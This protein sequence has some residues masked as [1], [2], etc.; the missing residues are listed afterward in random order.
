MNSDNLSRRDTYIAEHRAYVS[1]L[2]RRMIRQYGLPDFM[3]EDLKAAGFLGL[4]EAAGRY[5]PGKNSK[6][7][8]YAFFRIRGSMID[9]LR[10]MGKGPIGHKRAY[11]ALKAANEIFHE[12]RETSSHKDS[13]SQLAEIL[14]NLS[15]VV[16]SHKI[17]SSECVEQ[18]IDDSF[19]ESISRR[20]E[21]QF[22]ERV[23]S[24]LPIRQR[25]V[26]RSYYFKDLNYDEIAE[27]YQISSK[28]WVCRLH[29]QALKNLKE[30][31]EK[32][33]RK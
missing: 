8:S 27:L 15:T 26:I 3:L 18:L 33:M 9:E 29:I 17:A 7:S 11:K 14:Q 31:Y 5:R 30:L 4:V 20:T 13:D 24:K 16:L 12:S 25:Q 23:I 6:F 28:S 22:L 19:Q 21:K 2:A 32:E 1:H 10:R